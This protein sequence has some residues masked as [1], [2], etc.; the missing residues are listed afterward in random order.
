MPLVTPAMDAFLLDQPLG[1]AIG[2][3]V[4]DLK[5]SQEPN[6][7]DIA[8]SPLSVHHFTCILTS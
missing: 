2:F 5:Q 1:K 8:F 6:K 4:G 7:L 3:L